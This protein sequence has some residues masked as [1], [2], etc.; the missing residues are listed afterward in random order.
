MTNDL[1]LDR[2]EA[3]LLIRDLCDQLVTREEL[4][5]MEEADRAMFKLGATTLMSHF[6]NRISDYR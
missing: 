3:V 5:H 1:V 4:A 6:V 2:K